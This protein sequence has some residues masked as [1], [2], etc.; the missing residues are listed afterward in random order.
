MIWLAKTRKRKNL[1]FIQIKNHLSKVNDNFLVDCA[2]GHPTTNFVSTKYEDIYF[3]SK[4]N[5]RH[6]YNAT[7]E[8]IC[9]VILNELYHTAYDLALEKYGK[10]KHS[11]AIDPITNF[12]ITQFPDES[13]EKLHKIS[14]FRDEWIK[15]NLKEYTVPVFNKFSYDYAFGIGLECILNCK[16]NLN[17][18]IV[19]EFVEDFWKKGEIP[20]Y[21]NIIVTQT[22]LEDYYSNWFTM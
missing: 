3:I 9:N 5:K 6:F 11:L 20:N 14:Q 10:V 13:V 17:N 8:P 16:T 18:D 2:Y 12:H 7:V 15:N 4:R 21:R 1:D 22:E 19:N